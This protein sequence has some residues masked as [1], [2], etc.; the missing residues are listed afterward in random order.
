ME[1]IIVQLTI[2]DPQP[3]MMVLT[4]YIDRWKKSNYHTMK[5]I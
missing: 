2:D 3:L 5:A 4:D 1:Y